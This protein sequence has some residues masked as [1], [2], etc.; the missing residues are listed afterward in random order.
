MLGRG[1]TVAAGNA[2]L[3]GPPDTVVPRRP[4]F[5]TPW[6][7]HSMCIS[8]MQ[9][10]P[11][12]G[13]CTSHDGDGYPILADTCHTSGSHTTGASGRVA[14]GRQNGD[15]APNLPD[16]NVGTLP[17]EPSAC[18]QATGNIGWAKVRSIDAQ[19]SQVY[20]VKLWCREPTHLHGAC[21][22]VSR[23]QC[24]FVDSAA[25]EPSW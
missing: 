13:V 21:Q 3:L 18:R 4:A 2:F 25:E 16:Q 11:S 12:C 7:P 10:M 20:E 15:P 19:W 22:S 6:L 5:R 24:P 8:L 23:M 14:I 9:F 17:R 1:S